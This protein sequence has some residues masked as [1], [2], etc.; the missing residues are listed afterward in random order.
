MRI[1]SIYKKKLFSLFFFFLSFLLFPCYAVDDNKIFNEKNIIEKIVYLHVARDPSALLR[2]TD[3]GVLED[4][5]KL[6]DTF[7]HE[8]AENS[9]WQYYVPGVTG[10]DL[11]NISVGFGQFYRNEV[12]KI[13]GGSSKM[14]SEDSDKIL[15]KFI[16]NN[17]GVSRKSLNA[18]NHYQAQFT[19]LLRAKKE[20]LLLKE[21]SVSPLAQYGRLSEFFT[22]AKEQQSNKILFHGNNGERLHKLPA[23]VVIIDFGSELKKC[24]NDLQKITSF[25]KKQKEDA[26]KNRKFLVLLCSHNGDYNY[27]L[28]LELESFLKEIKKN[29]LSENVIFSVDSRFPDV[30]NLYQDILKGS[31]EKKSI[32]ALFADSHLSLNHYLNASKDSFA[33]KDIYLNY[34]NLSDDK[35]LNMPKNTLFKTVYLFFDSAYVGISSEIEAIIEGLKKANEETCLKV[36]PVFLKSK[37]EKIIQKEFHMIEIPHFFDHQEIKNNPFWMKLSDEEKGKIERLAEKAKVSMKQFNSILHN[38][39]EFFSIEKALINEVCRVDPFFKTV[40]KEVRKED[41]DYVKKYFALYQHEDRQKSFDDF[42]NVLHVENWIPFN[43]KEKKQE[44]TQ[45]LLKLVSAREFNKGNN[46][47]FAFD[48]QSLLRETIATLQSREKNIYSQEDYSK[49]FKSIFLEKLLNIKKYFSDD[50]QKCVYWQM[51]SIQSLFAD[52]KDFILEVIKKGRGVETSHQNALDDYDKLI[53]EIYREVKGIVPKNLP[54]VTIL[55][56]GG[57][58]SKNSLQQNS[59]EIKKEFLSLYNNQ[60]I[61]KLFSPSTNNNSFRGLFAQYFLNTFSF[62]S[63]LNDSH[64]SD[65]IEDAFKKYTFLKGEYKKKNKDIFFDEKEFIEKIFNDSSSFDSFMKI[66]KDTVD[67][68][69]E[70]TTDEEK[71]N[72]YEILKSTRVADLSYLKGISSANVVPLTTENVRHALEKYFGISFDSLSVEKIRSIFYNMHN[73]VSWVH[74]L[75]EISKNNHFSKID[76]DSLVA[77][78]SFVVDS[79]YGYYLYRL[80]NKSLS[81]MLTQMLPEKLSLIQENPHFDPEMCHSKA[82]MALNEIILNMTMNPNTIGKLHLGGIP[83]TGKSETVHLVAQELK[84]IGKDVVIFRLEDVEGKFYGDINSSLISVEKAIRVAV[85]SGKTVVFDLEEIDSQISEQQK[86]DANAKHENSKIG[87]FK[88]FY[89]RLATEFGPSVFW[90][91]TTNQLVNNDAAKKTDDE[92]KALEM[93]KAMVTRLGDQTWLPFVETKQFAKMYEAILSKYHFIDANNKDLGDQNNEYYLTKEQKERLKNI[94]Q[95]AANLDSING[96]YLFLVYEFFKTKGTEN[97]LRN[98]EPKMNKLIL[99]LKKEVFKD[100]NLPDEKIILAAI[101]DFLNKDKTDKTREKIEQL[102]VMQEKYFTQQ[103]PKET[104]TKIFGSAGSVVQGLMNFI[105]IIFGEKGKWAAEMATKDKEYLF[106]LGNLAGSGLGSLFDK[107]GKVGNEVIEDL[108]ISD[109]KLLVDSHLT[110]EDDLE[111][112]INASVANLFFMYAIKRQNDTKDIGIISPARFF[113]EYY[114]KTKHAKADTKESKDSIHDLKAWMR[115]KQE[116]RFPAFAR[117]FWNGSQI[118]VQREAEHIYDLFY[119]S[120]KLNEH[121]MNFFSGR[122]EYALHEMAGEKLDKKVILDKLSYINSMLSE[123]DKKHKKELENL[124][125]EE[126]HLS[127]LLLVNQPKEKILNIKEQNE[128]D[129]NKNK[130][131]KT[132]NSIDRYIK[133]LVTNANAQILKKA[134]EENKI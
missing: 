134:I 17:I 98:L 16:A 74:A 101:K 78:N 81:K 82:K 76:R 116:D 41:F 51:D 68:V 88:R 13:P 70:N 75:E 42:Y 18:L 83:G 79:L 91:S 10:S 121:E 9:A 36:V 11:V 46:F 112:S 128:H 50:F 129:E 72:V 114:L 123:N 27:S 25:F 100:D 111:K 26:L 28:Y 92:G 5:E 38:N 119:N 110:K 104:W 3:E 71:R 86:G 45:D 23:D 37:Q 87:N 32:T 60:R 61:I 108:K 24:E 22:I 105:P 53:N 95:R 66:V 133:L 1:M 69:Y 65:I 12:G 63:I 113:I 49:Y 84:K 54:E 62:P 29:N 77:V 97:V 89:D 58:R 102:I 34:S 8:V 14:T 19:R 103:K 39:A 2:K 4:A 35:M 7:F 93:N 55:F 21:Y 57:A 31:G 99:Y 118:R 43:N 47:F 33:Q 127:S 67:F 30:Q 117:E 85:L 15:D 73:A 56:L 59:I 122:F 120:K 6:A 107:N 125:H 64:I 80:Q 40:L 109:V 126:S 132:R 124:L 131:E 90:Y 106:N 44:V 94:F 52:S 48:I 130:L 96:D 115:D 20:A